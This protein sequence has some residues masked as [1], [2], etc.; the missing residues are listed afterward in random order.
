M[1]KQS[2]VE[3]AMSSIKQFFMSCK[4]DP[5]HLMM[6]SNSLLTIQEKVDYIEHK[7]DDL[8]R[9]TLDP[10]FEMAKKSSGKK[11]ATIVAGM[12]LNCLQSCPDLN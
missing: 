12:S 2:Y 3:K 9:I 5:K 6:I 11:K 10:E 7:V 4:S 1:K 8:E